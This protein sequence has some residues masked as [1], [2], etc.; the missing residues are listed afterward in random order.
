M[1]KA[2]CG[3]ML[4][5]QQQQIERIDIGWSLFRQALLQRLCLRIQIRP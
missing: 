5:T 4:A 3:W 2:E 1:T